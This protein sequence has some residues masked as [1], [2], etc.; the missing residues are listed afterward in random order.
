MI[1]KKLV[2]NMINY[3][4]SLDLGDTAI[5]TIDK[6]NI[7]SPLIKEI[8]DKCLSATITD[9]NK[10]SLRYEHIG[11]EVKDLFGDNCEALELKE[12]SL[13]YN[14]VTKIIGKVKAQ[15]VKKNIKPVTDSSYFELPDGRI[16]RYRSCLL[17]FGKG[18]ILENVIIGFSW[19]ISIYND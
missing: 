15:S 16:I 10:M 8:W 13:S 1:E 17:P 11:S 5:P 18:E 3:W 12:A 2:N 4:N 6:L 19:K 7:E 9:Q 14:P